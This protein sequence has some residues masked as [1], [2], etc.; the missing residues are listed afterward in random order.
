MKP[1]VNDIILYT[2]SNATYLSLVQAIVNTQIYL[3]DFYYSCEFAS[4]SRYSRD[5]L[6]M[7]VIEIFN[8]DIELEEIYEK[9]PEHFI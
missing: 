4:L 3:F 9:Y 1:K 5:L 6:E 8:S 7:D 2:D